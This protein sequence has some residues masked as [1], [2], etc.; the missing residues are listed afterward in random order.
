MAILHA[1]L[2]Q[3]AAVAVLATQQREEMAA[4]VEITAAVVAAAEHLKT[5]AAQAL[6]VT[7]ELDTF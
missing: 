6:E 7:A 3:A 1:A 2:E 5:A 4:T